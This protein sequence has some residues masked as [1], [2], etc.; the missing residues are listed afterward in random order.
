MQ[1]ALARYSAMLDD[2]LE[3]RP[4]AELRRALALRMPPP[5]RSRRHR[6]PSPRVP[7]GQAASEAIFGPEH[8]P[9]TL[10]D[11]DGAP[12]LPALALE[13]LRRCRYNRF[14][15]H[16]LAQYFWRHRLHLE[17]LRVGV[18]R[19]ELEPEHRQMRALAAMGCLALEWYGEATRLLDPS[20]D[21]ARSGAG[22]AALHRLILPVYLEAAALCMAE[23]LEQEPSQ[24]LALR[25]SRADLERMGGVLA[26]YGASID[27]QLPPEEAADHWRRWRLLER[28]VTRLHP[29]LE[30]RI[31]G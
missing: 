4:P 23:Q 5:P 19:L 21:D 31:R 30:A 20:V 12:G 17:Q 2:V 22:D 15:L 29:I 25:R 1:F 7:A 16:F 28:L 3:A 9:W 18:A 14:A 27:G 13:A 24:E 6:P 11:L 10:E 26:L 8:I